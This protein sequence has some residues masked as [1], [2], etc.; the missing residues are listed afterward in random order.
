MLVGSKEQRIG[1][2]CNMLPN[3]ATL[4]IGCSERNISP[5]LQPNFQTG[6]SYSVLLPTYF[7]NKIEDYSYV[8]VKKQEQIGDKCYLTIEPDCPPIWLDGTTDPITIRKKLVINAEEES[9]F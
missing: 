7:H 2:Y 4:S 8:K 3:L 1:F 9:G 6:K 5:S